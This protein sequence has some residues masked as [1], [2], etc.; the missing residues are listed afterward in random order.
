MLQL[1]D[2]LKLQPKPQDPQASAAEL[3]SQEAVQAALQKLQQ[4]TVEAAGLLP[5]NSQEGS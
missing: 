4:L 2:P 1:V 5:S 3:R